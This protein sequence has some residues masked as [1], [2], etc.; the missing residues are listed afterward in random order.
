MKEE[1]VV[2]SAKTQSQS[3]SALEAVPGTGRSFM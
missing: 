3:F 1:S 2:Q